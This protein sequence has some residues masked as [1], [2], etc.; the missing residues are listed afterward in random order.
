LRFGR[1][2][3]TEREN[4]GVALEA[5]ADATKV[6]LRNLRALEAD[7]LH[8]LPRGVFQR[9]LLRS[10]CRFLGLDED[11]WLE[12][13]AAIAIPSTEEQDWAQFAE[14]VK[15]GRTP[16]TPSESVRWWGVVL[17]LLALA[18]ASFAVWKY[19][20]RPRLQAGDTLPERAAQAGTASPEPAHPLKNSS[21]P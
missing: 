19:I 16:S 7:D 14:N 3:Q 18:T 20:V 1:E 4:R 8:V 10:Y 11:L 12:K 21:A 2:L 13:F 17:L 5:V 15:R 6:S 9:G